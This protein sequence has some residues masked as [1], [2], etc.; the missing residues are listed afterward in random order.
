[1]SIIGR[2]R[3]AEAPKF[4]PAEISLFQEGDGYKFQND[5][6]HPYYVYDKDT[7]TKSNCTD[8]CLEKWSPVR[9]R[10]NAKPEA[11]WTL[12]DRGN[13]YL[14]WAYKGKPVYQSIELVMGQ[15]LVVPEGWHELKP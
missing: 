1:M 9:A 11:E 6:G 15:K 10:A 4:I 8:K 7:P 13:G 2:A 12:V 3:A 14:Q 5:Q